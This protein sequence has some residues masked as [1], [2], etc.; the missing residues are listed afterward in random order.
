MKYDVEHVGV[1]Q[2][3]TISQTPLT[4]LLLRQKKKPLMQTCTNGRMAKTAKGRPQCEYLGKCILPGE[5]RLLMLVSLTRL[6]VSWT[7][8]TVTTRILIERSLQD[9]TVNY[10]IYV[11]RRGVYI[12]EH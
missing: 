2:S 3:H 6:K 8:F 4:P 7:I 5:C 10:V 9:T 11:Y 12:F 1:L